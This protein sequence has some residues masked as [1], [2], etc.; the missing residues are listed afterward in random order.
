VIANE[1]TTSE[2]PQ[3]GSVGADEYK[4]KIAH[5][6]ATKPAY[7]AMERGYRLLHVGGY[8][9]ALDQA[10]IAMKIEPREGHFY[11]LQGK[12]LIALGRVEYGACLL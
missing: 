3:G 4:K 11:T 7:E 8:Q 12:A 6:I 1:A 5:L 2:S 9:G 10:Q